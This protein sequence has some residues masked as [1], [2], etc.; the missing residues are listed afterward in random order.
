M[1]S[2]KP[3][4]IVLVEFAF[5]DGTGSKRRPALIVSSDIYNKNRQEVI[6]AA[7]TSNIARVLLGDTRINDWEEAGL[8]YPS[9]VTGIIRTIKSS[10]IDRK[11]GALTKKDFQRVQET[12]GKAVQF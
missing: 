2:Y 5:T 8:I 4:D 11:L 3:G 12:I 1:T 6:V 10:M 7:I 9:L